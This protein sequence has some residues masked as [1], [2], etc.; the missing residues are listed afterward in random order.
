MRKDARRSQMR[1]DARNW[2][3]VLGTSHC[4]TGSAGQRTPGHWGRLLNRVRSRPVHLNNQG[5][6]LTVPSS[7]FL[8]PVRAACSVGQQRSKNGLET[9]ITQVLEYSV[10]AMGDR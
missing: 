6:V 10:Y 7:Q 1:K 4:V 5:R 9:T 3:Q 8:Q 2:E